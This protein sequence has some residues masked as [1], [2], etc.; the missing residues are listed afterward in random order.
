MF[1]EALK[2]AEEAITRMNKTLTL[3]EKECGALKVKYL[4]ELMD[5]Q[6]KA[7]LQI[8]GFKGQVSDVSS[9]YKDEIDSLFLDYKNKLSVL[10]VAEVE[11]FSQEVKNRF[12][13]VYSKYEEEIR[14][15]IEK[16]FE[17]D[18]EKIF[19]KYGNRLIPVIFKALI[20]YIF[21]IKPKV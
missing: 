6:A 13:A 12:E 3:F 10:T 19:E 7:D 15:R 2:K 4:E 11:S 20:R 18:I 1:D 16:T 21:H 5:F 9:K 14:V 8:K 17:T